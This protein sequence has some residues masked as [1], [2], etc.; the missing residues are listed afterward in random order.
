MMHYWG[1]GPRFHGGI[2]GFGPWGGLAGMILALVFVVALVLLLMMLL[3]RYSI[4]RTKE[5]NADPSAREI[6]E[7]RYA[8]GELT[9]E[10]FQQM[11]DDLAGSKQSD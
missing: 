4:M 11:R 6:L 8:R 2:M 9:R 7:K 5:H 1:F 3:R 10:Q